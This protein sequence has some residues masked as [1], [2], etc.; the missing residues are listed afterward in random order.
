MTKK[1]NAKAQNFNAYQTPPV[2]S[3]R[4]QLAKCCVSLICW[5]KTMMSP[6]Y[7]TTL[8]FRTI[9]KKRHS[10]ILGATLFGSPTFKEYETVSTSHIPI[11]FMKRETVHQVLL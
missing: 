8:K 5:K 6:T 10:A 4:M 1:S 3:T 2:L 9:L 7:S 11:S